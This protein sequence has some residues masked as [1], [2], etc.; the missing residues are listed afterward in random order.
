MQLDTGS[1]ITII[2]Q[3]SWKYV[4]PPQV[5][6][7]ISEGMYNATIIN[8]TAFDGIPATYE[9]KLKQK[10]GNAIKNTYNKNVLSINSPSFNNSGT[11]ECHV[12][13][14][15]FHVNKSSSYKIPVKPIF[16]SVFNDPKRNVSNGENVIFKQCFY[17]HPKSDV[18][19]QKNEESIDSDKYSTTDYLSSEFPFKGNCT[20]LT[21]EDIKDNDFGTYILT[22][23]N[24]IGKEVTVFTLRPEEI[25]EVFLGTII[26]CTVGSVL[27]LITLGLVAYKFHKIRD[28]DIACMNGSEKTDVLDGAYDNLSKKPE[29]VDDHY[30]EVSELQ[31]MCLE[32]PGVEHQYF[33]VCEHQNICPEPPVVEDEHA[34][35]SEPKYVCMK[36]PVVE[37][38]HAEDSEPKYVCM[39]QPV[40]EDEHAEDSEPK[41]VCMKQPDLDAIYANIP[42]KPDDMDNA[43]VNVSKKLNAVED[44]YV[45]VSELKYVCMKHP[46]TVNGSLNN[47]YENN[48]QRNEITSEGPCSSDEQKEPRTCNIITPSRTE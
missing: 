36:Q 22:V 31:D 11:W 47:I 21:I 27:L 34:E 44:Y 13:N 15:D 3:K 17:S 42:K 32:L 5:N 40:V 45:E 9:Y 8:C 19:W 35:D 7:N 26:G 2:N 46:D 33:E 14:K 43:Y 38:E 6:I 4:D 10:W 1:N 29:A 20:S 30:I 39:K 48:N 28:M 23:E 12:S 25:T 41:Y 18:K 37:D 24:P 16:S